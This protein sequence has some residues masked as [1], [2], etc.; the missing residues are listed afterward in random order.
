MCPTTPA[1]GWPWL[2]LPG[3]Y[4]T[5]CAACRNDMEC[6]DGNYCIEGQCQAC[7]V[8]KRCGSR[9]TSCGGDTP[10]CGTAQIA[11]NASCVRCNTDDQCNG[12]T[13]DPMAHT[14]STTCPMSCGPDTPYCDGK[15]CVACYADTQCPCGGTCDLSS[16][17]CSTS[18]KTNGDCQ[19]DQ[20]CGYTPSG[21]SMVCSPGPL[22]DNA[23]CGGTL[24][25]LCSNS[26]AGRA[27]HPTPSAGVLGL[28]IVAL[29]LRRLRRKD[30]A[31]S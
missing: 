18:C 5:A 15:D 6:C 16:H 28:S 9:C 8:D 29:L 1:E 27:T 2:C 25:D 10:F 13:C 17:T 31:R 7:L 24:A 26:I 19:G 20:H 22:P 12:G 3:P 21:S 23:D 30:G 14:C 11:T 4:G